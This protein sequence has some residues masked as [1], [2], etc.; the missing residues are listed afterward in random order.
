MTGFGA[1]SAPLGEGRLLLEVRSLNHRFLEARVRL[2]T[3]IAEQAFYV[4]QRCRELLRRGRYDVSGR[5]EGQIVPS[6]SVDEHRAKSAYETLCR[7]RDAVAPDAEVPLSMLASVPDLLTQQ[8]A[9]DPTTVRTA[10]DQALS[11]AI[12][13]L[14]EMRDTE[15]AFLA[16]DLGDRL[17]TVREIRNAIAQSHP[18]LA[19][20]FRKRVKDRLAKVLEQQEVQADAT[21]LEAELVLQAERADVAEELTRLQ[22][23]FDQFEES[24]QRE[25]PIGR[26]L[27]FLLQ[28]IGR[29]AN[30]IGSKCQD[31]AL[32]HLVV[33]L[34]TELE[35]MREQVQNVE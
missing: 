12:E 7:I 16:Q 6:G 33:D 11:Q 24:C 35:R 29:E 20:A 10:I 23:H 21:R 15:G 22:M 2:P 14:D 3:E 1:G 19:A 32:A 8:V 25:E 17:A 9:T 30:T 31:A 5:L 27:E 34:K 28:E 18:E 26:R 4:E 13:R